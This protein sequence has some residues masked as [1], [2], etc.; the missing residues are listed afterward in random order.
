MNFDAVIFDLDGTLADTLE[1]IADNMNRVLDGKGFPT[2]GY[3]A[4]RYFVGNGLRNLVTQCLPEKART[5]A[6]I[7][8]CHNRMIAEY[9]LHYLN[10][11]CLYDGIP[12]LLDALSAFGV[13]LAVLSNKAEQLTQKIC[14][15]LLKKWK[16]DAIAGAG[17][18]FPRKPNPASALFIVKQLGVKPENVCYL[19]D[20]DVDM[21]T[22]GAAG[23]YPVGAGW[24]FRPKEELIENGA[25]LIIEYPTEMLRQFT[26]EI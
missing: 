25:K 15:V 6:L 9:S 17:D 20:S 18:R 26:H 23:F 7:A 13:K 11:T 4:Y 22:A 19:G 10:K 21:K 2:H 1:D 24:G 5:E 14:A 3:D 16:F 12:E 8:D